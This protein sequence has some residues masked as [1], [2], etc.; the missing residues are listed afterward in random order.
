MCGNNALLRIQTVA[1]K[2]ENLELYSNLGIQ[3]LKQSL[4]S[5]VLSC[6]ELCTL[7]MHT[8]FSFVG[9]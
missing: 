5:T 2:I 7:H 9:G 4:K 1:T 6:V 8:C 3:S